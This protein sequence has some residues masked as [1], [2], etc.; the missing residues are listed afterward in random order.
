MTFMDD[1]TLIE[2]TYISIA[3][4]RVKV[5]HS[6]NDEDYMR[7]IQIAKK[8]DLHPNAVNNNLKK[9]RDNGYV[10]VINPEYQ[11]PRLYRLTA[12]GKKILNILTETKN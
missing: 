1:E 11:I 12:K 5:L 4:N 10:Y 3:P 9:L 7:P 8:L 6:F 2:L